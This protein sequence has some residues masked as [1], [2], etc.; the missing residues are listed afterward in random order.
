MSAD[1]EEYRSRLRSALTLIRDLEARLTELEGHHDEPI[2]IIGVG[3]RFPGGANTPERFAELLAHGTC[4]VSAIPP[5][6]GWPPPAMPAAACRGAFL[7]DVDL[8]DAAFFGISPREAESLD[9]QQRLLLEVTWEALERAGIAA[10]SLVGSP[11]GVFIGVIN[12][13]YGQELLQGGGE[14]DHFALTGTAPSTAAGRISYVL[15]LQGPCVALDTACSSS[16]VAIH[17]ACQSLRLGES[18]L[19]VAGGTNLLLSPVTM[20]L[21]AKFMALAADG[22][23]KTFDASADGIGRGE[24]VGVVVLKRLSAALAARDPIWAV[25]RGSAVNHDGR[26]AALTV[27]STLSQ[28]K[29]LEQAL[30]NAHITA[31]QVDYVEL[32]GTGT[33]LGDPIE[34]EALRAVYGRP[35]PDGSGCLLGSVKTNIGHTEA[36]AG[37]AGVIKTVLALRSGLIPRNLHFTTLNPHID[38]SRTPLSVVTRNQDWK[39]GPRRRL[40]GVSSFGVSGTN[41]HV[42]LEEAPPSAPEPAAAAPANVAL[43]PLSARSEEALRAAAA[44]FAALLEE[45]A[46]PSL[47]D[48]AYS[49]GVGRNHF[50]HRLAVTAADRAS[51][52]EALRCFTKGQL[53]PGT[54][55]GAS[56]RE[57]QGHKVAF[58]FSGWG[59]QWTAMGSE[60]LASEPVFR[61]AVEDCDR[62]IAAQGWPSVLRLL[63]AQQG[64]ADEQPQSLQPVLFTLGVALAALWESW[65]IVP[66][67]VL[68][69]SLGEVAAAHVA[70][71][72]SLTDAAK[73]ICQRCRVLATQLSGVLAFVEL[74]AE[75]AE[76]LI[77]RLNLRGQVFVAGYNGPQSTV[78]GGEVPAVDSLLAQLTADGIFCR[79][80][81]SITG[82]GHSPFTE[83]LRDPLR[84]ALAGIRPSSGRIPICSTVTGKLAEGSLFDPDYWF[85]NIRQPVRFTD[86]IATLLAQRCRVFIELGPHP[87]L[88]Q[89]L[90]E[91]VSATPGALAVASLRRGVPESQ[92]MRSSLSRLYT[93]GRSVDWSSVNRGGRRVDLP[94]Y[95]FQRKRYWFQPPHPG[96]ASP[97]RRW[98]PA[99]GHPL[100]ADP[101]TL[102]TRSDLW[103]WESEVGLA[104]LPW[105]A[106]HRF[107][108]NPIFP[109]SAYIELALAAG[110]RVYP[111]R[112][113]ELVN[114]QMPQILA[115]AAETSARVQVVVTQTSLGR[116]E[117]QVASAGLGHDPPGWRVHAQGII[118][119]ASAPAASPAAP[120]A[121][122]QRRL[123]PVSVE[124]FYLRLARRGASYGPA[125]RGV[126]ELRAAGGEALGRVHLPDCVPDGAAA[127]VIHPVLLDACLQVATAVILGEREEGMWLPVA[128]DRIRVRGPMRSLAYSYI[129]ARDAEPAAAPGSIRK[130]DITLLDADGLVGAELVGVAVQRVSDP[131]AEAALGDDSLY[132][133][134]KWHEAAASTSCGTRQSRQR[135]LILADQGGVASTLQARLEALGHL[136]VAVARGQ[137]PAGGRAVDAWHRDSLQSLLCA[138]F[139]E[140]P[141]GVIHMAALDDDD[142]EAVDGAGMAACIEQNCASALALLQALSGLALRPAPRLWF[143]TRGA[144]AL[145][146]RATPISVSQAPLLGLARVAALE[147]PEWRCTRVDLAPGP[148]PDCAALAAELLA[149]DEQDAQDADD[150]EGAEDEVALHNGRRFLP[151]LTRRTSWSGAAESL[152]MRPDASYLLVGGL[153]ALGLQLARWLAA[154]GAKNLILLGRQ[155]A[156]T[157][158]KR[159]VVQEL[160]DSGVTVLIETADAADYAQLAL[161]LSRMARSMPPLRGVFQLATVLQDGLLEQQDAARFHAVLGAKAHAAWNLHLLTR[162]LPLDYF[163]LFSSAVGLLGGPGQS[164]Y[165]AANTFLDALS[166]ERHRL[167][168]PCLSLDLGGVSESGGTPDRERAAAR[169]H[170]FAAQLSAAQALGAMSRLLHAGAAQAAF[171]SLD[172]QR[173]VES[174]P[175]ASA[176]SLL[177]TLLA[178]SG[179]TQ[180]ATSASQLPARLVAAEAPQ[181]VS[182]V[183]GYLREEIGRVLRIDPA[184]VA[185]DVPLP[186]LGLDSLLGLELRNRLSRALQVALPSTIVFTHPLLPQLAAALLVLMGLDA[187]SKSAERSAP[188]AGPDFALPHPASAAAQELAARMRR[189]GQL[190]SD[191]VPPAAADAGAEGAILLTGA[192]GF[193]GSFLLEEL[194]AATARTIYCLVQASTAEQG[195]DRLQRALQAYGGWRPQWAERI[196]ALPGDLTHHRLRQ[197][198][199]TWDRLCQEVSQII[200]A[201]ARVNW[202][203][204]YASLAPANVEGTRELIL[205]AASG[206]GKTIHHISTLAVFNDEGE[207]DLLSEAAPLDACPSASTSGYA[208]SKWVAE[209]LMAQARQRGFSVTVYRPAAIWG[210]SQRGALTVSDFFPLFVAACAEIGLVP[211]GA[212]SLRSPIPADYLARVVRYV[213]Q[214]DELCGKNYHLIN[215]ETSSSTELAA[216]LLRHGC[217]VRSV[218]WAQ[219]NAALLQSVAAG[220]AAYMRS[221]I[222]LLTEEQR[223][224]LIYSRTIPDCGNTRAVF[225]KMGERC[226]PFSGRVIDV[227]LDFLA[228]KGLL[229]QRQAPDGH[230]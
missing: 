194:L 41:G 124:G 86:A 66:D 136:V 112:P 183:E 224:G 177:K 49:A 113:L 176:S 168:L 62:A 22:K 119:I 156:T 161:A 215:P 175:A 63:E 147:H 7:N 36:A 100:L 6:R 2:A 71:V 93:S 204:P 44:R 90:N 208:Q 115:L 154:Q 195:L 53:L 81:R 37:V 174:Y 47:V 135:F 226:P 88:L 59:G 129:R 180:A 32:H 134:I 89:N 170:A 26:S 29:V 65:G 207:R 196:R 184:D 172:L 148:A 153:G 46:A 12:R 96:A 201:G 45:P 98:R 228:R 33:A 95:P 79:R 211:A 203:L 217:R 187:G 28:K 163:V 15:G 92:E 107:Q 97:P 80:I 178:G 143:V 68:G 205:L 189:D 225:E 132:A 167:G 169:M 70:G 125:F 51:A 13:D 82:A 60:L 210:H 52:R 202:V 214:H 77:G 4:T 192:T 75:R 179:G 133:A 152:P 164:S 114:I 159:S 117:Y 108:D 19:A 9:P 190:A 50:E 25:I 42:I 219:W 103:V 16:L 27:P 84:K 24:G 222:E 61:S 30:N 150:E 43:L 128:V 54:T 110:N 121:E 35:R 58:V 137:A 11:T 186:N 123:A 39:P 64:G 105:L 48:V 74:S 20:Q 55:T 151:R 72:L 155:G 193:V 57:G 85:Q 213:S 10:A 76:R 18:A 220:G 127:Y 206:A 87:V 126:S 106:D 197:D 218:A 1:I 141:T 14:L 67:A 166:H 94:T 8:F 139:T 160:R 188:S 221:Y 5:E 102:S 191:I 162:P 144:Q 230:T 199:P 40:A 111:Q 216:A 31:S 146:S 223:H 181:R 138:A 185:P 99:A 140:P 73:V 157:D 69:Y 56:L 227:G 109:M 104:A 120:L 3:C 142:P 209:N 78:L 130:C 182:L 23:C 145:P 116:A 229:R 38:L 34:A 171:F 122:L 101:L 212:T 131:S 21:A 158:L 17:L 173:W 200:H 91:M 118:H 198:P 83:P 149:K 165:A